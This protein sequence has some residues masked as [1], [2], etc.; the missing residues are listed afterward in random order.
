MAPPCSVYWNEGSRVSGF[1]LTK[2]RDS[3]CVRG[4]VGALAVGW[5]NSLSLVSRCSRLLRDTMLKPAISCSSWRPRSQQ[6]AWPAGTVRRA[7]SHTG[8]NLFLI[9]R[10]GIIS[11]RAREL[12]LEPSGGFFLWRCNEDVPWADKKLGRVGWV[13]YIWLS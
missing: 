2:V 13:W 10:K 8:N 3:M 7:R 11:G 12:D 5:S 6:G 9:G 1:T 4:M